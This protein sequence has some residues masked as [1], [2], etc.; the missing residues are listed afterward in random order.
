MRYA[1][2]QTEVRGTDSLARKS[3]IWIWPQRH[4]LASVHSPRAGHASCWSTPVSSQLRPSVGIAA[5]ALAGI[6]ACNCGTMPS[7]SDARVAGAGAG[8]GATTDYNLDTEYTARNNL[9]GIGQRNVAS[10]H[11]HRAGLGPEFRI[12]N[13]SM[14]DS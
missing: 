10:A 7:A 14:L 12:K 3:V 8:A 9:S 6:Q 4:R 13:A 11:W 2:R 1:V 5:A